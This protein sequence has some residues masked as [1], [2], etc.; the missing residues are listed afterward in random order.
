M[1]Q[2]TRVYMHIYIYVILFL[3]RN[4]DTSSRVGT[5]YEDWSVG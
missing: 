2:Y 5:R 3:N 4:Y 1:T